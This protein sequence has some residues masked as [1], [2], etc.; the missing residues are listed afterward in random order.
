M[1]SKQSPIFR[2]P[3]G[4]ATNEHGAVVPAYQLVSFAYE[5]AENPTLSAAAGRKVFDRLLICNAHYPGSRDIL[6]RELKRWRGGEGDGTISDHVLWGKVGE[7]AERFE[8]NEGE[9]AN[10]TPIGVMALDV[11]AEKELELV[12][13]T[14]VEALAAV[15][16]SALRNFGNA[17]ELR[18]RAKRFLAAQ[19]DA[20]P[21]VKM[22]AEAASLRDANAA[23]RQELDDLKAELAAMRTERPSKRKEAA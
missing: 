1:S 9:K 14:T 8:A 13:V 5:A 23:M 10:G 19:S 11:I 12:N 4:E 3:D 21:M 17:R 6:P 22:E 15:P 16:D 2:V 7:I 18:D 20:A